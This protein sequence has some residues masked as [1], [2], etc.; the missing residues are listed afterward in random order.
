AAGHA[1]ALR[2]RQYLRAWNG[3]A[4]PGPEL[5]GMEAGVARPALRHLCGGSISAGHVGVAGRRPAAIRGI[6]ACVPAGMCLVPTGGADPEYLRVGRDGSCSS[7]H[8]F[9]VDVVG[10]SSLAAL[11]AYFERRLCY[12]AGADLYGREPAAHPDP[13]C[14]S[15]A[16]GIDGLLDAICA[17]HSVLLSLHNRSLWTHRTGHRSGAHGH[18]LWSTGWVQ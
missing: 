10:W 4:D 17:V 1:E 9:D 5:G 14:R 3:A 13:L 8:R 15:G 18:S 6:P 16:D 11:V 7:R 2:G 12:G